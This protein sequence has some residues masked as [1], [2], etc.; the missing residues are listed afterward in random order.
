MKRLCMLVCVLCCAIGCGHQWDEFW[1]DARGDNMKMQYDFSS[2][3]GLET[4]PV[5]P[6]AVDGP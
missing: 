5:Q 4:R 1:K 2:T 6:K 3:K